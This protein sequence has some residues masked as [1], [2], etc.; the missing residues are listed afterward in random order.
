MEQSLG[1]EIISTAEALDRDGLRYDTTVVSQSLEAAADRVAG[2]LHLADDQANV[3]ALRRVR[4]VDNVP[5]FVLDNFVVAALCPGLE[6]ANLTSRPLFTVLEQD[7]G[8]VVDGVQRTFQ[9]QIATRPV[10]ELLQISVGSPVL[11]LEQVSYDKAANPIEYSDVWIRGDRLRLSGLVEAMSR[12]DERTRTSSTPTSDAARRGR[13]RAADFWEMTPAEARERDGRDGRR[14][15]PAGLGGPRV[16]DL[17]IP[18]GAGAADVPARLYRPDA[19]TA[20]ELFVFF[21]G[22]G[23]EVGS[24]ETYDRP[25]RR[26]ANDSGMS[27]L[28]VDYRL[29]PEHPFPAALDDCMTAL[30]WASDHADEHR[31][32][33]RR[34]WQSAATVRAATSPP[35]SPNEPAT[36]AGRASTTRCCSTRS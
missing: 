3:V 17:V 18:A 15:A 6:T 7:Y 31:G 11:Y 9:A 20:G 28:S 35:P 8:V 32:R 33:R 12:E 10:A 2:H 36:T 25:I 16:T 24:L 22:G 14:H 30:E 26:L 19:P 4:S 13:S 1:Q 34:S 21:H 27:V 23:W 29:A 5:T